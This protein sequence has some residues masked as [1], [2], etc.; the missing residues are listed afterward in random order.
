MAIVS[1]ISLKILKL[2]NM[3]KNKTYFIYCTIFLLYGCYDREVLVDK[4][5]ILGKDYRI[6]QNTKAWELAK[7]V[8]DNNFEK[9]DKILDT[10]K[11]LINFQESIYGS[12]VLEMTI[13]NRQY[14]TFNYLLKKGADVNIYETYHGNSAILEICDNYVTDLRYLK[15]V[16]AYH[17]NVNDVQKN[18]KYPEL[19]KTP[20]MLVSGS[21]YLD[22]VKLLVEQGANVNFINQ[23]GQTALCLATLQEANNVILFLLE[24]GADYKVPINYVEEIDKAFYLQDLLRL[25]MYKIESDDYK[26]KMSIVEFLKSK[27]IDYFKVPIPEY[28]IKKA[29][30]AYPNNWE[31]YL[32]K[33]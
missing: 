9:I 33:Y 20:L 29:K 26:L 1:T 4:N 3:F 25:Q 27:G 17:A 18:T 15:D 14:K 13:L 12:T 8:E 11:M 6:F 7:A 2:N 16:I 5:D 28:A 32:K 23:H 22:H 30:E 24:H 21:G 19:V 31:D 10:N